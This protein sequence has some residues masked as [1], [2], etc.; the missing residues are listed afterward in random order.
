M[1]FKTITAEELRD[2]TDNRDDILIL[3]VRNPED[4]A[5]WKIEGKTVRTLNIPYF[6]FLDNKKAGEP[7]LPKESEVIIV[8]AK[9]VSSQMVT[10][11]L[12]DQGYH[13][14]SLEG[15][16]RA[17]SQV[18]HRTPVIE[19]ENLKLYQVRRPAKGCLSYLMISGDEALVLDPNRHV[20]QYMKWAEEDG[21]RITTIVDTHMH[22]DHISGAQELAQKTGADYYISSADAKDLFHNYKR[23]EK[24]DGVLF[25][26]ADV[27]VIALE[28]PGHTPGSVSL[29]VKD[30]YLLSGDTLFVGGPGR[31]DLGGNPEV[32]GKMLFETIFGRLGE[33]PEDIV[34]FPG[35]YAGIEEIDENGAVWD[36]LGRIRERSDVMQIRDQGQFL[37]AVIKNLPETP[38]NYENIL[39]VNGGRKQVG[40]EEAI[41]MET[42]P[43]NC[44]IG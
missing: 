41:D 8:C 29:L 24:Q 14:A 27:K 12:A 1:A 38:P 35:H 33:M 34:V 31:P 22:A 30:R 5:Y 23:L 3:D 6:D 4:Y 44:A 26:E 37:Q 13:V 17:W 10:E 15:G 21:A 40:D 28:T 9:G 43:N 7:Y 18:Y 42:G 19:A 39:Q 11:I 32:R 16:M 20:D 2:K 36:T 25:G